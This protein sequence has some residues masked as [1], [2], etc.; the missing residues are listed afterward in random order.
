MAGSYG[1]CMFSFLRRLPIVLRSGCTNLHPPQ[2]CRRLP[3][4]HAQSVI[5]PLAVALNLPSTLGPVAPDHKTPPWN[6]EDP[7]SQNEGPLGWPGVESRI[8]S[9]G[10]QDRG[11]AHQ[12]S[13]ETC[14]SGRNTGPS[15]L[16]MFCL[17]LPGTGYVPLYL[18]TGQD[19]ELCALNYL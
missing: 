13:G 14:Q 19:V 8:C 5:L 17:G 11:A 12:D 10:S 6:P 2:L 15:G 4:L 1:N 16:E 3:F 18:S 9:I 7:R